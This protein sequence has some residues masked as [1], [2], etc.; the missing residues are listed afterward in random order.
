[1]HTVELYRKVCLAYRDGLN[2]R[3]ARHFWI[4]RES[5]KKMLSFFG[6]SGLSADS[7]GSAP[8]AGRVQRELRPVVEG[9]CDR[10]GR[11]G[12]RN[13]KGAV[14]GLVG[15]SRRNFMVPLPRFAS[16]EA[17]NRRLEE[18]CRRRQGDILR[19]HRE[20]IGERLRRDLEAM[21]APPA[22]PFEC[23]FRFI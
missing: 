6:A 16:W 11:P 10:Y 19:G 20:T 8:E 2:E 17:F 22:A 5:V 1:M 3:A 18:Q 9:V 15:F 13:D 4:S 12:K 14:E 7:A 21:S 23:G